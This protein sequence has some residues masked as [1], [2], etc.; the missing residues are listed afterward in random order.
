M[1]TAALFAAEDPERKT[2]DPPRLFLPGDLERKLRFLILWRLIFISFL[3]LLTLFLEEK[4]AYFGFPF[5]FF[6][7]YLLLVFQYLLSIIYTLWF[8]WRKAVLGNALFQLSLDGLFITVLFYLSGGIESIFSYLYFVFILAGANLLYRAGGLGCALFSWCSYSLI[9]LLQYGEVIPY[10]F[11]RGERPGAS[12][13]YYV[14]Y[15][16]AMNGL[17]FFLFCYFGSLLGEQ[18][19]KQQS[20]ITLQQKNIEQ[21]EQLHRVMIEN[22]EMGLLTLDAEDRILSINPAGERI[23]GLRAEA[24]M[25]KPF[26]SLFAPDPDRMPDRHADGERQEAVY[27]TPEGVPLTLGYS[28]YPVRK[29]EPLGIGTIVS[30]KDITRIKEM[31]EQVRQMDRLALMGKVAAGIAHEIRNP[32]ASIS[33][34]IQVL[35]EDYREEDTGGRL[36]NIISRE[37][38]QLEGLINGFLTFSR[39]MRPSEKKQNVSQLILD[40]L[41]LMKKEKDRDWGI[42]WE[43]DVAPG[44]YS[45]ISEG[46]L[47]QILFNLVQN[48]RQ[49]LTE[50]GEIRIRARMIQEDRGGKQ[51]E[52]E[53]A[54]NGCGIAEG[55]LEK[56]F[57]PFFTTKEKGTGLGLNIVQK[58]VSD[59][60]GQL[61]VRSRLGEGTTVCL[62]LP[63]EEG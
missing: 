35:K 27:R 38:T 24:L 11:A 16:M 5:P 36:L 46:E 39:P 59:Y 21:L 25:Q 40:T 47:S 15:Q 55:D 7:F 12:S 37:L 33:G 10:Y 2:P 1:G 42:T 63:A 34:A 6:L 52:I 18:A 4:K 19:K 56:I 62:L 54:D 17:G 61:R 43:V 32:L 58:I 14:L 50:K 8:T 20:Q 44:L 49:A 26:S 31:E 53:V 60:G 29:G 13:I 45:K 23:L 3:L 57:D 41:E 30:F 51:I 9:V 22:L 28:R 48:A